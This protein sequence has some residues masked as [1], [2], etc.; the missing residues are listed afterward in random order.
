[1]QGHLL[2]KCCVFDANIFDRST[3]AEMLMDGVFALSSY[4]FVTLGTTTL[5]DEEFPI[6]YF[7]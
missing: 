1:M 2:L 7:C 4:L 5:V 6:N 3:D